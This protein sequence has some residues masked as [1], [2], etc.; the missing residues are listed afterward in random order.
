MGRPATVTEDEVFAAADDLLARGVTPTN[1]LVYRALGNRGSMNTIQPLLK[2]WKE[3]ETEKLLQETQT[4]PVPPAAQKALASALHGVW[5]A[6]EA[7]IQGQI[8]DIKAAAEKRVQEAEAARDEAIADATNL[9][10][11]NGAAE[12]RIKAL[13]EKE[14]ALEKSLAA[15]LA[16]QEEL[17]AR[18][19]AEEKRFRERVAALEAQEESLERELAAATE[20]AKAADTARAGAEALAAEKERAAG[21]LAGE[22][23]AA[24]AR[25]SELEKEVTRAT[26]AEKE[27][28]EQVRREEAR[29]QELERRRD[30][31]TKELGELARAATAR[32]TGEPPPEGGGSPSPTRKD[33]K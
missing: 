12:E 16:V 24:R 3:L 21:A 6:A 18:S 25:A 29:C 26:A 15:A 19:E 17:R 4:S 7:E 13:L 1:A 31:L 5:R 9:R 30:E 23:E 22:A 27:L 11:E 10:A 28:R 33:R 20:R 8:A 2:R 14:A 32:A